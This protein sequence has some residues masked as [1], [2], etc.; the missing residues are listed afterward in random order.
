MPNVEFADEMLQLLEERDARF[1]R[2]AYLHVLAALQEVMDRLPEPRHIS[3]RELAEEVGSLALER[4]GLMSRIVLEHW[5][6][7]STENVGDI[8]FALVDAGVLVKQDED[9]VEDFEDVFD[10]E[11]KFETGY[12]WGARIR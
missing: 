4:Y 6:V 9:R 11:E 12:P 10:F 2:R 7:H 5:G 3:A 1:D 8:V